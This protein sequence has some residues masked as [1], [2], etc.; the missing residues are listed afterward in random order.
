MKLQLTNSLNERVSHRFMETFD[1]NFFSSEIF[2]EVVSVL[3]EN[4]IMIKVGKLRDYYM[5]SSNKCQFELAVNK[6]KSMGKMVTLLHYDSGYVLEKFELLSWAMR[7][8][9]VFCELEHIDPDFKSINFDWED[10][11]FLHNICRVLMDLANDFLEWKCPESKLANECFLMVYRSFLKMQQLKNSEYKYFCLVALVW[12]E[13]FDQ[14]SNNLK[15]ALVITVILDPRFKQ[16]IVQ[17]FYKEIYDDEADLHFNQILSDVRNIYNEYAKDFNSSSVVRSYAFPQHANEVVSSK[18]EFDQYLTDSK[19]SP[20][21][22][23]DILEWWSFNSL[24]Y[25]TLATMAHDFL[26]IPFVYPEDIIDRLE[27]EV[28]NIFS[29]CCLDADLKYALGCTKAWLNEFESL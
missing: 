9:E 16:D 12:R 5:I 25:P 19:V 4:D 6:V 29:F 17:H 7:Y 24:T 1:T 23:F 18:L 20:C 21:E 14:Y 3:W 13:I 22:E 2:F 8:E 27:D 28:P 10:A 15:L 26:C 11:A